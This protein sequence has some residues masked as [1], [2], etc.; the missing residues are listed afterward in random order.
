MTEPLTQTPI[1][2]QNNELDALKAE[3]EALRAEKEQSELSKLEATKEFEK[4]YNETKVK[5]KETSTKLQKYIERDNAKKAS[6]LAGLGEKGEAFKDLSLEQVTEIVA[7]AKSNEQQQ[8]GNLLANIGSTNV[9]NVDVAK[10][11]ADILKGSD[12]NAKVS[13]FKKLGS[14]PVSLSKM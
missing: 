7:L 12:N 14:I 11:Q 4:L 5:Y 8:E 1:A 6:L 10:Q 2:A 9:R 3:L 13:L